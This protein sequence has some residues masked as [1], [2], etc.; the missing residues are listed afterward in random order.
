MCKN[1]SDFRH[2]YQDT[3]KAGFYK[4]K[5]HSHLHYTPIRNK[6]EL[7]E[8]KLPSGP[9]RLGSIHIEGRTFKSTRRR[10]HILRNGNAICLNEELV[11]SDKFDWI[12]IEVGQQKYVTSTDFLLEFGSRICFGKAGFE[13]QI[14]LPL[15]LWGIEKVRQY[16]NEKASQLNLFGGMR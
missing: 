7:V 15:S 14:S 16:R 2:N 12:V 4:Q 1:N 11:K 10:E 3:P 9:R 13:V 8:L 5:V 6:V